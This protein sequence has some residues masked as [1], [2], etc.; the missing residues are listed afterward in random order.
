MPKWRNVLPRPA[1]ASDGAKHVQHADKFLRSHLRTPTIA[2]PRN[3]WP[4]CNPCLSGPCLWQ[5][6][7]AFARPQRRALL[8]CYPV[9][10]KVQLQPGAR[11]VQRAWPLP[12]AA[13]SPARFQLPPAW[14][15]PP[16]STNLLH[17]VPHPALLQD[18]QHV[19]AVAP[20]PAATTQWIQPVPAKP[21]QAAELATLLFP[22]S[23]FGLQL[24]EN[25]VGRQWPAPAAL[26]TA[27]WLGQ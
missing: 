24:H 10:V 2:S 4:P 21:P 13:G 16:R 6:R 7:P 3:Q 1:P 23:D 14:Y 9:H 18:H 12:T 5:R 22:A 26:R 8:L 15:C 11:A 19:T 27:P 25:P 17:I 20:A